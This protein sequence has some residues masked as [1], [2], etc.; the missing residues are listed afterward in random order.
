M[1]PN[2]RNGGTHKNFFKFQ[3]LFGKSS[4][5]HHLPFSI[6]NTEYP[7]SDKRIA[8]TEPPKPEPITM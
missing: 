5:F 1:M 2:Q 8:D 6:T 4:A 3:L 7:F